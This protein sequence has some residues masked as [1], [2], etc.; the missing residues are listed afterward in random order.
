MCF[1]DVYVYFHCQVKA[2][3]CLTRVTEH[4]EARYYFWGGY[5]PLR[6]FRKICKVVFGAKTGCMEKPLEEAWVG[7]QG[8][9]KPLARLIENQ[10]WLPISVSM[11][12]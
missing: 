10:I 6:D 2:W 7:L 1:L 12:G 9:V 11:L 4:S 3:G 8:W 5:E